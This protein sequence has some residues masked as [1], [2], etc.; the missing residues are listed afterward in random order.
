MTTAATD[1]ELLTEAINDST[2]AHTVTDGG[3]STIMYLSTL[4]IVLCMAVVMI[5]IVVGCIVKQGC[6]R[7]L[8]RSVRALCPCMQE[9]KAMSPVTIEDG[10]LALPM[11]EHPTLAQDPGIHHSSHAFTN[12]H[13]AFHPVAVTDNQVWAQQNQVW[14][15]QA[16]RMAGVHGYRG[17]SGRHAADVTEHEQRQQLMVGEADMPS[18]NDDALGA[19]GRRHG[20]DDDISRR[21]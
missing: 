19:M 15:G 9:R 7:R 5:G 14:A 16:A 12:Y 3:P 18:D 2:T 13:A 6:L 1:S 8:V 11:T 20:D 10:A 17:A 4:P 21:D